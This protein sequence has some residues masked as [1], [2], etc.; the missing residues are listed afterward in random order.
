VTDLVRKLVY[1]I[2]PD[3]LKAVTVIEHRF[4]PDI[5]AQLHGSDGRILN[6]RMDVTA[7]SVIIHFISGVSERLKLV[8]IG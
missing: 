4:G 2:E 7:T 8:I 1:F 5:I 6:V 3:T